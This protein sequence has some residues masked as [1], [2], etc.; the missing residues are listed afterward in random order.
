[1]DSEN[2]NAPASAPRKQAERPDEETADAGVA[3]VDYETF[4]KARLLTAEIVEAELHPKADRLLV[5]QIR[6]GARSKQI[7]AGIRQA[8]APEELI[9]KTIVI[10]DN[11]KPVKLRG[12]VSEGMLL[13]AR[14]PEGGIRLI[15]TDGPA[16]SGQEIS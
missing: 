15:T 10:V 5:L 12:Q 14:L 1:M 4:S 7:V 9:G 11:L 3:V 2:S 16:P 8:Y 6:V 13:A